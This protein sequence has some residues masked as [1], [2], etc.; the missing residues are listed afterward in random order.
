M[1][2][3]SGAIVSLLLFTAG[4]AIA[5]CADDAPA[6]EG[7]AGGG[8]AETGVGGDLAGPSVQGSGGDQPSGNSPTST[9]TGG[10]GDGGSGS[11]AG[12]SSAATSTGQ[13]GSEVSCPLSACDTPL[14][15]FGSE[16]DFEH[17]SSDIASATGF[18][19]HRGRDMFYGPDDDVWLLGKFTYGILDKDLK[20][21]EIDIWFLRD[22]GGAW[23][24]IGTAR[25]TEEDGSHETIEGV[26]DTGGWLYYQLPADLSLG[27]GRHRF[28]LVVGGDLSHTPLYVDIVP[29]QTPIIVSDVDGT[30][31]TS[32]TEEFTDLLTGDIPASNVDSPQVLT[33][34]ANKGY[35]VFYLTARPEFLVGRTREFLAQHG[36][37][38]GVVHTTLGPLGATGDAA[39]EY[40]VGELSAIAARGLLPSW[41]FGNTETD[42]SA[43]FAAGIGP[44]DRRIMFQFEDTITGDR[45]IQAYTEL[46]PEVAA[47]D[48]LCP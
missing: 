29:P 19:N 32:E 22:C 13:G 5:G 26:E 48:S 23:E 30:L 18:A 47:T 21:E 42:A 34:L 37:P 2:A 35:R 27:P 20:D 7:G 44:A 12:G 28:E 39:H 36:Y 33:A 16:R 41:A 25:T 3:T 4:L 17:T 43:F 14:P 45:T 15:D 40:K 10:G 6:G 11:G 46:L 38:P 24:K 8:L 31:T 9:S 1:K